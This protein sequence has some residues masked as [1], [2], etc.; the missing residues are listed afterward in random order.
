MTEQ[1][2]IIVVGGGVA[3]L[4]AA[5]ALGGTS[6]L[7]PAG[8]LLIDAG[9]PRAA[10]KAWDGR[11]SAITA[12][13][14]R[15]CEALGLWEAI[16]PYAE[17]MREI[18]VSDSRLGEA[19]RPALLRFGEPHHPQRPSAYMVE[20]HRLIGAFVN[21]AAASPEIRIMPSTQAASFAF[22][23]GPARIETA[24][25]RSLRASLIVAADGQDSPARR[26]AGIAAQ[27]WSY[28]QTA[29][30][31]TVAHQLPHGGRA[32]E[33]FLPAGP[34]A[35]LPL[36]G[37]RSSL[38]WTETAREARRLLAL[39][40]DLFLVEL[41]LR[42]GTGRGEVRLAGPRRG[43]PLGLR[44]ASD[45]A[46]ARLALIGDA[47]HVVHPIAGLGL[48]LGLRDVAALAECVSE[49]LR[50]G[51][52]PGAEAVLQDYVRWR[53][54][55]TLATAAATDGLNRLFSNDAG[56]LRAIRDAGLGAVER[57]APLKRLFMRQ[58][59][60]ETGRLPRLLR[61]EPI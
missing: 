37:N 27:G 56:A 46:A 33:H 41:M 24:D 45:F 60:G 51:L 20:N 16:A 43:Y 9:D 14:R 44:I 17:P 38:V 30:V 29:I 49:A 13:S 2:D 22:G 12:S 10:G 18:V 31:T 23:P 54:F 1:A 50:L 61:G 42:F 55:D 4:A 58:A 34:F 40:E 19:A 28:G 36:P 21:A 7:R 48:N 25:G 52:D 11:A 53:R 39:D 3:G 35:I 26:A 5:I 59:A 6:V 8:V 32:E 15:M 47:A 57:I